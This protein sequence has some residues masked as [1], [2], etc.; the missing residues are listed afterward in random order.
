MKW[1]VFGMMVWLPAM[2]MHP[3]GL[4]QWIGSLLVMALVDGY[5][6]YMWITLETAEREARESARRRAE[7]DASR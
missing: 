7:E 1:L 3:Q 5:G 6:L 4:R 2:A